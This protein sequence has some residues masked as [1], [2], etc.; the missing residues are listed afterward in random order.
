MS[1]AVPVAGLSP[2]CGR[3]QPAHVSAPGR[4]DTTVLLSLAR[5][6]GRGSLRVRESSLPTEE[7]NLV[8]LFPQPDW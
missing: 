2:M 3:G 6:S 8:G 4:P 7:E 5:R 1:G